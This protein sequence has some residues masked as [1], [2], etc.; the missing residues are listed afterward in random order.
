MILAI[1]SL[2]LP[3]SSRTMRTMSSAWESSL[4]KISVLGMLT[5][6][7]LSSTSRSGNIAGRLSRNASD[8]RADLILG[9]DLAVESS[10][11]VGEILVDGFEAFLAGLS[12]AERGDVAL[13]AF[14]GGAVLGDRRGESE[15]V[16]VDV[17]AVGDG[18]REA[19]LH[20]QVLVEESERLLARRGGEADEEG[21]EVL[22]DLAPHPVDRAVAFVDD[23]HVER[24][25]RQVLVVV[26]LDGPFGFVVE[27]GVLVEL[28]VEHLVA[29]QDRIHPLD[30]GDADLGDRVDVVRAEPLHVV[31]L[32]E[33][34]ARSG[35]VEALELLE[36]L[37]A[38]VRPIDQEQDALR[39]GLGDQPLG[40][41]GGGERLA[42]TGRHLDQGARL[43]V[44][45]RLFEVGDRR[46]LGIAQPRRLVL[47]WER[48]D[49]VD[50]RVRSEPPRPSTW[51]SIMS[52]SVSG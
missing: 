5:R 45:E 4:A 20:H 19:V 50:T 43:V 10:G 34:A 22:E 44:L 48:F 29:T 6:R 47:R 23:D 18:L 7:P 40:D 33:L 12:V 24:L 42:R 11:V 39:P 49:V 52:A 26:D 46:V 2:P 30:R 38:E 32:A 8:D 25:D 1:T 27:R 31:E 41:V 15:H 9:D 17:H 37:L 36:R 51:S 16:E 35:Y 3:N 14:D 13:A 28:L 21:V